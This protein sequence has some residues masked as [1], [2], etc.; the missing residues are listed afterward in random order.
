MD[1][2]IQPPIAQRDIDF[3][4][5]KSQKRLGAYSQI[6]DPIIYEFA[7]DAFN[8]AW[9]R[10][11]KQTWNEEHIR[12]NARANERMRVAFQSI[13]HIQGNS[14][15]ASPI[16]IPSKGSTMDSEWFSSIVSNLRDAHLKVFYNAHVVQGPDGPFI[17]DVDLFHERF[18]RF[19]YVM[20]SIAWSGGWRA[21]ERAAR[22]LIQD[23][24]ENGIDAVTAIEH[25][26][27]ALE[28]AGM[29]QAMRSLFQAYDIEKEKAESTQK[30]RA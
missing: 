7:K 13:G 19:Y 8:T 16:T 11:V 28:Q 14:K 20:M 18:T 1:S 21:G 12:L 24:K 27:I 30:M 5:F 3:G 22:A 6:L 26:A 2:F 15:Q 10:G 23:R 9:M 4:F 29:E 17:P 25:E